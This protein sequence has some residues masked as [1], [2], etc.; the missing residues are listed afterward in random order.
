MSDRET[1][2]RAIDATWFGAGLSKG[3]V[4]R[5]A[6]MARL[7]EAPARARLLR[8]GEDTRELSVLVEG[9]VALSE[10]VAGRGA[11]TL[12]T[13]EPGDI[14]GWSTLIPPY[15]A[16]STVVSMEAVTVVAFDGA[17]LREQVREDCE[18][19]AGIYPRLLEALARRLGA[20]RR[21][22]ID[23]YG[24]EQSESW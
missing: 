19:A 18:L 3:V 10:H 9:R 5:L 12:L 22:L 23:V 2:A 11:V 1:L 17:R 6:G 8:E 15:K 16:T 20:T 4:E 7:Y 21:Q 24:T 14:F 13:V